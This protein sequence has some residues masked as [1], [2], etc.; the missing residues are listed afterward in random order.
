MVRN[1]I[2]TTIRYLLKHKLFSLINIG[3]LAL[4]M[5]GC[6]IIFRYVSFE[7][8]FDQF[9]QH[10]SEIYR[11]PFSAGPISLMDRHRIYASNVPA[12]GPIVQEELPE[13]IAYARLLHVLTVK[14]TFAMAYQATG[15]QVVSFYE[16]QGYYADASLLSMFS[17]PLVL[18]NPQTALEE[19]NGLVVSKTLAEKYFGSDWQQEALGAQIAVD[20]WRPGTFTVTGVLQDVPANSQ[21]QIDFRLSYASLGQGGDTSSWVWSQIYTY[22]QLAPHTN[23]E[24]VEAKLPALID[25]H[26]TGGDHPEMFLQPLA[27][28][29][30]DS[31]LRYEA[32]ATGSRLAVSFLTI[33]GLFILLIAWVNYINL[34]TVRSLERAQEVGIRKVMGAQQRSLIL[35]F[36]VE[37]L[38]MNMV[39][40]IV[41]VVAVYS[42]LSLISD[43]L[44]WK[45][46]EGTL[47]ELLRSPVLGVSFIFPGLFLIGSVLSALYPAMVLSA[48]SPV[49]GLKGKLSSSKGSVL[50]QGLATFQFA[51]SMILIMGTFIVYQ[52]LR[53]MQQKDLGMD[54]SQVM[55]LKAGPSITS[56]GQSQLK[57][58]EYQSVSG[59]EVLTSQ[60]QELAFVE[61][62]SA[63]SFI[64]GQEITR[65]RGLVRL[66]DPEV[67]G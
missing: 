14:N 27:D 41:A 65:T 9:H 48:F 36:I 13:V 62:V 1:F 7:S 26:Y 3:G 49:A 34:T 19:P 25:Q 39:A 28:I 58:S 61:E 16:D 55:V 31:N 51:V 59:L 8:S 18:G 4:G 38:L 60:L 32:G 21:L 53:Y 67:K 52:Q 57:P 56:A 54:I 42:L 35:Q 20:G 37:A 63:T 29:Y 17:F 24:L 44:H 5:A 2:V 40:F 15:D 50:R 46:P 6:L 12:F 64:P 66:D 10:A 11:V 47:Y 45:L 33:I 23:P 22:V 43:F 30:L